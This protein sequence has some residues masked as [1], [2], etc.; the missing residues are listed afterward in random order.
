MRGVIACGIELMMVGAVAFATAGQAGS[1]TPEWPVTTT[2]A[3]V[4]GCAKAMGGE[5][6]I[7]A[8]RTLRVEV[9]YTDHGD[10]PIVYEIR[11]P[12]RYRIESPGRYVTRFD[13]RQ[14]SRQRLDRTPLAPPVL[15]RAAEMA[16]VDLEIA[17]L[18]PA[19]FDYPA[20]SL[21]AMEV[22]GRR[23]HQLR[24]TL[25]LGATVT[26]A[27]DTDTFLI[28]QISVDATVDGTP[29][30]AERQWTAYREVDG[31]RYPGAITYQGR[32]RAVKTALIRAVVWNPS[33]PDSR[34]VVEGDAEGR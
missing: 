5:G 8:L 6:R 16:D 7:R 14:A 30:H 9:V 17:W 22:S 32:D 12:N 13:G 34:F 26:Y 29:F 24:V 2:T 10:K 21:G 28:H 15:M 25:P 27:I 1:A 23:C 19:F 3:V 33:L 4:A 18:V 11:R 20:E 31:L